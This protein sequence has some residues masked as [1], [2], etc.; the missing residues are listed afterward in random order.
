MIASDRSV[1]QLKRPLDL[2]SDPSA[3][4]LYDRRPAANRW[5]CRHHDRGL[6][7]LSTTI[8]QL[9]STNIGGVNNARRGSSLTIAASTVFSP[10][11][12]EWACTIR[13]GNATET[14]VPWRDTREICFGIMVWDAVGL[15]Q[16][17]G[18]YVFLNVGVVRRNG[19]TVAATVKRRAYD[20][21]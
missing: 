16:R 20:F 17:I 6:S 14:Y 8:M 13:V 3:T 2:R 7:S 10:Q 5:R 19:I 11:M 9:Y 1:W 18:S 4:T 21:T 15:N 12:A